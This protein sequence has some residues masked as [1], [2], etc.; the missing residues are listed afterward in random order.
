MFKTLL[1]WTEKVSTFALKMLAVLF[2][3]IDHIYMYFF[4]PSEG[5]SLIL[6]CIG[7]LA[8]PLF[9]F[10]MVWGYQYTRNRK[11]YLLRLYLGSLFMTA[12]SYPLNHFILP[13]WAWRM[14]GFT[15]LEVLPEPLP[16]TTSTFLLQVRCHIPLGMGVMRR[17]SVSDRMMFFEKSGSTIEEFR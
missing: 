11:V 3:F 13:E 12:F 16:P 6:T 9:L 14:L 5:A 17:R 2:M 15:K 4:A 1:R 10:C 8:Y 7:R